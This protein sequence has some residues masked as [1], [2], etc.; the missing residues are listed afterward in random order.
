MNKTATLLSAEE[1]ALRAY[2][3][4][5]DKLAGNQ[6]GAAEIDFVAALRLN[7]LL[8]PAR[9]Q[10][11]A[12]LLK[13]QRRADAEDLLRSGLQLHPQHPQLRKALARLLFDQGQLAEAINTL[14]AQPLPKMGEDLEYHALLAALWQEAGRY[15]EAADRYE[16]LLQARPREALWWLGL[17]VAREQSGDLAAARIAYRQTLEMSGLR[18]DLIEFVQNRLQL[19]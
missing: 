4:G 16:H 13:T 6:I 12:L 5:L 9:L 18:P 8:L 14:E 7:P 17:A 2:R 15:K 10:Q 1:Q 19:L 11:V 3:S